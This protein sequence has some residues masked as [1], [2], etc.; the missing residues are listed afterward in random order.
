MTKRNSKLEALK[1][2]YLFPEMNMRK[3]RFLSTHPGVS[4]ISLGI[5][6]T[7]EPLTP[8]IT[9]ALVEGGQRLGTKEGYSGYGPEQGLK[10]LREKIVEKFYPSSVKPEEV[11]I[12][13][14]AKCDLARL[15]VLFGSDVSVAVQDAAYPVYVDGSLIQGV[16]RIVSM[17]CS[18]EAHFFP[19]LENTPKTDIIYFCSPNNPTGA[20][21]TKEQLASLVAF[22]KQNHSI[23]IFDSAYSHYIQDESLPKSI[24]EIPG[25]DEVAIEVGSFS[26]IAGFTGVRL[27]WTIVPEA[28][29]YENGASV[30]ADWIRITSTLFNGASN[31]AQ[32]G[33]CAVLE[34][35]GL[36]EIEALR[37]FYMEN[38][39]ILKEAFDPSDVDI[40][41]GENAPYLWL[42]CPG[43]SS[44]DIFQYFLEEL[45]LVVT[46]GSGFGQGGEG[47]V[48]LA[49]FGH[50]DH[51]LM[52][53]RKLQGFSLHEK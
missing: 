13:D 28:L 8:Y 10:L 15:Q 4:L 2:N 23:I 34:D 18:P 43:K 26:K 25:A 11:F 19:V 9:Q 17:S 35:E 21:A 42:R 48:R 3:Q 52:A 41:G 47:F 1:A 30:R 12:S 40:F 24:F 33:G 37:V 31:I 7:T 39:R 38:T 36:K 20:V 16:K 45:H 6:D 5:G 22:A 44:W 32:W 29:K 49:A 51:I 14:G 27:G 46:P 53:A 50:R